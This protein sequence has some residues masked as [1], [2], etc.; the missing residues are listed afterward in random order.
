M[1]TQRRHIIWSFLLAPAVLVAVY[2]VATLIQNSDKNFSKGV[3]ALNTDKSVYAPGEA[4]LLQMA[5]LDP[6]GNT[7][8]NSNLNIEIREPGKWK[9][10]V[11]SSE[12]IQKLPTC[13][14]DNNVTNE[15][16]YLARF[17]PTVS[18]KHYLRLVNTDTGKKVST[19]FEVS[20][21]QQAVTVSR[22]GATRINPSKSDRYPM[23]ITLTAQED[24]KGTLVEKVPLDFKFAWYGPAKITQDKKNQILTWDV[25]L[26]AGE[27]KRF[28]YEYDAPDVSPDFIR[29]QKATLVKEGK[30]NYRESNQWQI[31]SD[32]IA[33]TGENTN[34]DTGGTFSVTRPTTATGDFIVVITSTEDD[35]PAVTPPSDGQWTTA[36]QLV[37]P[38]ATTNNQIAIFY[39]YVENSATEPSSYTFTAGTNDNTAWWVGSLSGIDPSNPQDEPMSGNA[40]QRDNDTTPAAGS[41]TT[42]TAGAFVL[43]AWSLNDAAVTM[44]GGS[45]AT[46]VTNLDTGNTDINV[47]S[48]TFASAGATGD[49]EIGSVTSTVDTLA[50]QWAFRPQAP[51]SFTGIAYTDD[52]TTPDTTATICAVVNAGTPACDATDGSGVF[53][54]DTLYSGAGDQITFYYDYSVTT[55][56]GNTVTVSDGGNIV[57]GDNLKVFKNTVIVRYETGSNITILQMDAYDST[58]N[59]EDMLFD[60]VD[61]TPDTLTVEAGNKLYIQTGYTFQP[62]GNV[63]T[64]KMHVYGTYAPVTET[65]TLTGFGTGTSRPLYINGGT[66]DA[67]TT[68]IFQGAG[69]TDIEAI[70]YIALTFSPTITTSAT[71]TLLGAVQTY[72][73]FTINPSAASTQTLTV[74]LGGTLTVDAADT[75]IIGGSGSALSVLDLRPSTTDYNISAGNLDITGAGKLDAGSTTTSTI[76]LTA[77]SG[78]LFT[79]NGAFTAGGSTVIMNPNAAV[80]LTSGTF[81]STN[82]FNNLSLTPTIVTT[83]KTYTF[84]SGAIEIN[85]DFTINP[86]AASALALTVA[87][88][89]NITVANNKTTLITRTTSAT[90]S[91][92]T[93]A[94]NPTLSSGNI[95]IATGGTLE[96]A[97]PS[98]TSVITLTANGTPFT[99]T[100]TYTPG[101]TTMTYA[102]ASTTGVT[103]TS[104]TYY[105]IIFNKAS[106]TFSLTTSGIAVSNDLT[107][108]AGV[109]DVVNGSNYP[110]TVGRHWTNTP[111]A[112]GFEPRGGTVTF[113]TT[114]TA[115]ISGSTTFYNFT[116]ATAGKTIKFADTPAV[117]TING[118]FTLTGSSGPSYVTLDSQSGGSTQ[119]LISHQGTESIAYASVKNSGCSSSTDIDATAV[120]NYDAGNNDSCWLFPQIG[121]NSTVWK[122]DEGVG[123][124]VYDVVADGNDG[125]L[126]G[127]TLPAWQTEDMCVSGKCLYF[128]GTVAK[129]TGANQINDVKTV[130]FW[131][132]PIS[133]TTTLLQLNASAYIS[134]SSG[135]LAANGFTDAKIYV[136]GVETTALS[137]GRWQHI[138]VTTASG[139]TASAVI[140]GNNSTS[141]FQGFMDEV[142]FVDAQYSANQV[143]GEFTKR[144]SVDGVSAQFGDGSIGQQLSDGLI[145][146]WKMDEASGA[147]AD[148]SGNGFSLTNNGTTTFTTGRFANGSEHVPA[149]S[150][151]FSPAS[152]GVAT[153]YFNASDSGPTDSGN[154]WGGDP[155]AFDGDTNDYASVTGITSGNL[156]AGGTNAPTAGSAISQVRFRFYGYYSGN[157]GDMYGLVSLSGVNLSTTILAPYSAGWTTWTTLSVPSGGWTWQKVNDLTFQYQYFASEIGD[158]AF[159]YSAEV[160]VTSSGSSP[161]VSAVSFWTNPDALTNY[162]VNLSSTANIQSNSSGVLAANGFTNPKIYVN[163]VEGTTIVADKWQLVTVTSDTP[164]TA[165]AFTVG[166]V[167]ASSYFDGTLDEVRIY[168]RKLSSREAATLYGWGPAPL[169]YWKMDENTGTTLIQ[170]YSGN[171]YHLDILNNITFDASDGWRSGKYGS[172]FLFDGANDNAQRAETALALGTGNITVAAWI[173]MEALPGAMGRVVAYQQ[174]GANGY[175]IFNVNTSDGNCAS[176]F[177]FQVMKASTYYSAGCSSASLQAVTGVWYHVAGVFDGS[178]NSVAVYVNGVRQSDGTATNVGLT[179]SGRVTLASQSSSGTNLVNATMDEVKIYN[180]ARTPAQII[181]D[182][183]GGHF[184]P[185]SPVGSAVAHWKFD[186]MQGTTAQDSGPN[187]NDLT[188]NAASWTTNGKFDGAWNGTGGNFRLSRATDPDLE[189]GI[190]DDF[191]ISTWF[192]SDSTSNPGAT[193]YLVAN[194]GPSGAAG[195][196]F[197]G[198]ATTGTVCFGI[199]DDT[200]WGPDI[201]SC[202]TAD[203]YD[204]NWHHLVGVRDYSATDKTYLY[205]DGIPV[206][207][208]SDSTTATLDAN[209]TFYVGDKDATDNGDEFTGDIDELRI[210]RFALSSDEVRLDFNRGKTA[211]LG[212]TGT[213]PTASISKDSTRRQYCPPGNTEG[214][215]ADGSDPSPIGEWNFDEN[216]GTSVSYDSSTYGRY[217]NLTAMTSTSWVPGKYGSALDFN[218]TSQYAEANSTLQFDSGPFT[219]SGW[220][221]TTRDMTAVGYEQV[222]NSGFD[223]NMPDVEVYI[224]NTNPNINKLSF[225]VRD[226]SNITCVNIVCPS[227]LYVVNDGK[228]HHFAAVYDDLVFY[229]YVDGYLHSTSNSTNLLSLGDVDSAGVLPRIGNGLATIATRY[230]QGSLDQMRAYNYARTPA[231]IAWEHSRGAP[232]AWYKL[233]ECE[234]EVINDT[235]GNANTGTLTLGA[236]PA[237]GSCTTS[238]AWSTGAAGAINSGIDLDGSDDY[239]TMADPANSFLDFTNRDFAISGW[240]NRDS[241]AT[242]DVIIAKRNGIATSDTGYLAYIDD[243]SDK[244]V[245]TVADTG[246]NAYSLTSTTAFTAAGW[247][248][249]M[250]VWDDDS[251]A[252]TEIY[253]NGK[254]DSAADSGTLGSVSDMANT[255]PIRLGDVSDGTSTMTTHFFDGKLDDIRIFNYAPSIQQIVD[256]YNNGAVSSN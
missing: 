126:A 32:A 135:T 202:S 183:N 15:P 92:V 71:Y 166:K 254:A 75:M 98:S 21:K 241:F 227:S 231:Q 22:S 171:N 250:I 256:V 213:T 70:A 239:I 244:L 200:S 3:L 180:Y 64:P 142:K 1:S 234:G 82:A 4:V 137:A 248:H 144:G 36:D 138:T 90:S 57:S 53:L 190:T 81:T 43:A 214:N 101:S 111:G 31:A 12:Q 169:A 159:A 193:E 30:A 54:I 86:T 79:L 39:N 97:T 11:M 226:A 59:N 102:P 176:R 103:V 29:L 91:L 112:T 197:Y 151:Y 80:T 160:E 249:F 187:D 2:L 62:G 133:T 229:L 76:T 130:S 13:S 60:A 58:A 161:S 24:F 192:R 209:T 56:Y 34:V 124:T 94:S 113:D 125:T 100:G 6:Q 172:G 88:A 177:V 238:G 109:L 181:E 240:F 16:D 243:S 55:E 119:W 167:G 154:I 118:L 45:W 179:T 9:K 136:N 139:I 89:G 224:G 37:S 152:G 232:A 205:V 72:D 40:V 255:A 221:R 150:Q 65:L 153:Y 23:V 26:K 49:A 245:F 198:T 251:A 156:T 73:D 107:I 184:A 157:Y 218:G 110:I 247:N 246:T 67:S 140:L 121:V 175:H 51:D 216:T 74:N 52:G 63:T 5:S 44:P 10:T 155:D 208:T 96:G 141:Y 207:N 99:R 128:E 163:G 95:N 225:Y 230:F 236:S 148:S 143:K 106:N 117:F 212:S 146:Y 131:V 14:P 158:A 206:A 105:N 38:T 66:F 46:R 219:V 204:G 78:T 114:T 145:G 8:C 178:T 35:A 170:D 134:A 168:N 199:D 182:M 242:D 27:T 215:C 196:A 50:A 104:G 237:A 165:D 93:G 233:D 149:S 17:T 68:I 116:A 42:A 108:T 83:G 210:Y 252:N 189:F 201:A 61:S 123:S 185:G 87:M 235:S 84:G 223:G 18:G 195:Y 188:L 122:L 147:P 77:T 211:V 164:I 222:W 85:G 33:I 69:D 203:L 162:Y 220:L 173:K 120:T 132:R 20:S 217:L 48:R 253:I 25:D 194:G 228:W 115:N 47:A 129:V 191:A 186:D 127:T 28:V 41:I 19:S 7:L 174:D